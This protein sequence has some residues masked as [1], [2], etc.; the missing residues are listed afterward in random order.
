[1]LQNL[2]QNTLL[3]V[4]WHLPVVG[5][6]AGRLALGVLALAVVFDAKA[7]VVQHRW[8]RVIVE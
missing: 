3:L 6:P 1:M 4:S 7:V 8:G 2:P 5:Y